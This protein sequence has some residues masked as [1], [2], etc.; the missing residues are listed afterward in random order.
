MSVQ[1]AN[2]FWELLWTGQSGG[3]AGAAWL[4]AVVEMFQRHIV[5][6]LFTM[7]WINTDLS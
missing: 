4:V 7:T 2:E 3:G 6:H 5:I 1:A